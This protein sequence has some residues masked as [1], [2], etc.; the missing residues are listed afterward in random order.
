M[1]ESANDIAIRVSNLGKCYQI[2]N[3]PRDR[4]KQFVVPRLQRLFGQPLKQYFREFWALK[5][6]SFEIKKGE[7]IGIIGRNGAGKSTLLQ[8]ICGTLNPTGG[9][10]LTNGRVAALL[11]L[12]SGFNPEFTGRENVYMNASVLGLSNEEIDSRY[13]DI[14]AFAD[15]GDFIDQPVKT[16]SSGMLVRLAFSVSAQVDPDILIVDEALGVGDMFFQAKCIL[17]MKNIIK[18]GATVFFVSHDMAAIKSLCHR[19]IFVSEGRIIKDGNTNEVVD[20]YHS[21]SHRIDSDS[22]R[23]ET[24][25][26]SFSVID[27]SPQDQTKR[28]DLIDKEYEVDV[29]YMRFSKEQRYGDAKIQIESVKLLDETGKSLQEICLFQKVRLKVCLNFKEISSGEYNVG[30]LIRNLNGLELFGARTA[31]LCPKI[32][33]KHQ[34]ERGIVWFSFINYLAGG[35]YTVATAV[36]DRRKVNIIEY[37]D[38]INNACVFR[39]ISPPDAVW[40][41]FYNSMNEINVT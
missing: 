4:L 2:Y 8:M 28:D 34:G 5:D 24:I 16:Y 21:S 19:A 31:E 7:T 38:W 6:V 39:S 9:S 22:L 10:I 26:Q 29:T 3:A 13:D 1:R 18:S 41:C 37:H 20:A 32:P 25:H 40:G 27:K 33:Y 30:F 11:E 36:S 17:R 14:V 35:V 12:G 15:I 23:T